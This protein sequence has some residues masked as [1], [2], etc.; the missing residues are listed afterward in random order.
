[1][2]E[3]PV[4][5]RL[6]TCRVDL[7]SL[8]HR[9]LLKEGTFPHVNSI[10]L[11]L[12]G[13][14]TSGTDLSQDSNHAYF[15]PGEVEASTCADC[16]TLA[17]GIFCLTDDIPKK[18]VASIFRPP[19]PDVLAYLDFSVSTTGILAGVKVGPPECPLAVTSRES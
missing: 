9:S 6:H 8:Y 17:T 7:A 18:K 1:M 14:L 16:V 3:L 11:L 2:K 5:F 10:H 15:S 13:S 4:A 19:S 12:S